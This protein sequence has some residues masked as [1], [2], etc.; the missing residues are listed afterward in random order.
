VTSAPAARLALVGNRADH[1][2]AHPRLQALAPQLP[3]EVVW[4]PTQDVTADDL[5]AD[6]D[7]IWVIPGS[8]YASKDGALRAIRYARENSVPYL[9]TCG[10]FQHALIEYCRNVLHI[11]DADDVQYDPDAATPLIVPLV[12]SLKGETAPLH[13]AAGSRIAE[14]F[15]RDGEVEVTYHCSYGLNPE[16]DDLIAASELVISAYDDQK[17]PRAVELREHP[18]FVATLFQPEL[19]S[20][21]QDIHPLI[22]AFTQ[23]MLAHARN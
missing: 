10:G 22:Q 14:A 2:P 13:L 9:G 1:V 11:A 3:V 8:P 20:T 23:A 7:G 21:P 12:C 18:F 5:L 16:F 19:S 17:A 4:V 15:G 6:Y